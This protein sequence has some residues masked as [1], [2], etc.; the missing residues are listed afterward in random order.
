MA[1]ELMVDSCLETC[2]TKGIKLKVED[3]WEDS[4]TPHRRIFKHLNKFIR[5][6][7][8]EFFLHHFM[9]CAALISTVKA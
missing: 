7:L 1:S 9:S 5:D 6:G 2:E 3:E 4:R 8:K